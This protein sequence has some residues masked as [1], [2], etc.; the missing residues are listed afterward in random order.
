MKAS[1]FCETQCTC[2]LSTLGVL[3][4][5]PNGG[6]GAI[7]PFLGP[8]FTGLPALGLACVFQAV[9]PR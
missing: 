8:D 2:P 3:S 9:E 6:P 7:P 5:L 4:P 1:H